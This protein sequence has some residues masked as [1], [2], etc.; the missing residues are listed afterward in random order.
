MFLP[1]RLRRRRGHPGHQRA[2]GRLLGAQRLGL[3]RGWLGRDRAWLGRGD[4]PGGRL[5]RAS[6]PAVDQIIDRAEPQTYRQHCRAVR[7]TPVYETGICRLPRRISGGGSGPLD[8]LLRAWA[9]AD[10]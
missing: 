1:A 3:G 4:T 7:W 9:C 5:H 8:A 6:T 2:P 10:L